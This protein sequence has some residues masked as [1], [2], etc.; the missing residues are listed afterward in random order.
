[1]SDIL[2][3]PKHNFGCMPLPAFAFCHHVETKEEVF[4]L[5]LH[6]VLTKEIFHSAVDV[7]VQ[8]VGVIGKVTEVK[9]SLGSRWFRIDTTD[10]NERTFEQLRQIVGRKFPEY[11]R[12]WL[13]SE[14]LNFLNPTIEVK[15]GSIEDEETGITDY[16]VAYLLIKGIE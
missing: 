11:T 3:N 2:K 7:V 8:G 16:V 6:E 15:V 13:V 4:G 14:H 10:C 12:P 9:T 5:T 1:M